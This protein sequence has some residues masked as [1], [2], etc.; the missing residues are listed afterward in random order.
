ML[1]IE[2]LKEKF[3]RTVDLVQKA[4]G[5]T[6]EQITGMPEGD[7]HLLHKALPEGITPEQFAD[8]TEDDDVADAIAQEDEEGLQ[9]RLS[10]LIAKGGKKTKKA[11]KDAD[12]DQETDEGD[13]GDE[14]KDWSGEADDAAEELWGDDED[15]DEDE[16]EA[17]PKRKRREKKSLTGY[18]ED[19]GLGEIMDVEDVIEPVVKGLQSYIEERDEGIDERLEAMQKSQRR[20]MRQMA[21]LQKSLEG[22]AMRPA[23]RAAPYRVAQSPLDNAVQPGDGPD[24]D[25]VNTRLLKAQAAGVA[26]AETAMRL[27]AAAQRGGEVWEAVADDYERV[28]KAVDKP[29]E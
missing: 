4:L 17:P 5:L 2:Q 8:A 3:G 6:D 22:F 9:K 21:D 14:D 20:M 7:L 11:A 1:T 13:A 12:E 25:E 27:M 19:E 15:E 18:L 23:G 29:D 28:C 16:D 24:P 26:D 10:E